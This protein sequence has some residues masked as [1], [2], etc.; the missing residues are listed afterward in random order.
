MLIEINILVP[1]QVIAQQTG[2]NTSEAPVWLPDKTSLLCMICGEKFTVIKRRV[3]C[4]QL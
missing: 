2:A 1:G 3:C 4:N